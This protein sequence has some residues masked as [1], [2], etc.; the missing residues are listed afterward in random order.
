MRVNNG[1]QL[2]P[3][4][5]HE[6]QLQRAWITSKPNSYLRWKLIYHLSGV[7]ELLLIPSEVSFAI[8]VF[9]I[10]PK[11]INGNVVFVKAFVYLRWL[12]T[13][14]TSWKTAT[15]KPPPWRPFH[16]CNSS[17]TGGRLRK[18]PKSC[19][20]WNF[21]TT[22][23]RTRNQVQEGVYFVVINLPAAVGR[24]QWVPPAVELSR[25]DSVR[26]LRRGRALQIQT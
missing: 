11:Y 13:I 20:M 12:I 19:T 26:E 5:Y 7:R 1:H 4:R 21:S 9:N 17:E 23:I 14:S 8:C 2:A 16:R 6:L 22:N 25:P 3:L 10:Q 24:P 18:T 15:W